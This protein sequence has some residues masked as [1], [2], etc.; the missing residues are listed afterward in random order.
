HDCIISSQC[1]MLVL[2]VFCV[3][4]FLN[5][6]AT[7][8]IYTLFLHDALPICASRCRRTCTRLARAWRWMLVTAS[9]RH[10]A[11]TV[12]RCG[13]GTPASDRK[14]TRLNSSHVKISYAV[15]C[16]KKKNNKTKTD[17]GKYGIPRNS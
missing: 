12:S 8:E 7:T 13:G 4:F 9:R 16:L 5:D 10:S 1:P 15:F 11:S 17:T 2:A 3:F 14:S 6:A